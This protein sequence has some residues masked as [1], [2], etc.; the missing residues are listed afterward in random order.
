MAL[1]ACFGGRAAVV[2]CSPIDNGDGTFTYAYTINNTGGTFDVSSWSLAFGFA[3]ALRDWNPLDVA[4]GGDVVVPPGWV[5]DESIP[6]VG[7]DFFSI[8]LTPP[9]SDVGI[10]TT[11]GGFSFVSA[12]PPGSV[13]YLAFGAAG[14]SDAGTTLG[15]IPEPQGALALTG[16]VCGFWLF[17]RRSR[18]G[19][20]SN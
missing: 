11:L 5:S 6:P 2:E 14:E 3:A 4:S 1:A 10:G 18:I 7:Q 12:L 19:F 16:V 8:N 13:Q 9:T 20:R 15:P 17:V